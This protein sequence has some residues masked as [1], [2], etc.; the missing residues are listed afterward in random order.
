MSLPGMPIP[1]ATHAN[2]TQ[3][4]A[5]Q[6][7]PCARVAVLPRAL[8]CELTLPFARMLHAYKPPTLCES[9]VKYPCVC[10]MERPRREPEVV[11]NFE[12]RII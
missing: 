4:T 10:R 12:F 5:A 1:F 2:V 6:L 11:S 3:S 8:A 7:R 9:M